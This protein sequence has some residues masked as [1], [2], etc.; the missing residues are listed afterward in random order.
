MK[1]EN[2]KI[3]EA[4]TA[5]L[6]D[7]YLRQELENIMTFPEFTRAME[8]D[9]CVVRSGGAAKDMNVPSKWI[10]VTE[11]LPENGSDVLAYA[12]NGAE[13]RIYPAN[14]DRGVWFDC[15]FHTQ[16]LSTTHWMQLPEPP[17]T[18]NEKEE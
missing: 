6:Y 15:V 17:E 2:G 7:R 18:D 5:E 12:T 9:G 16:V 3:I 10:P 4:T 8:N 14:Y 11:R 1:I 13:S